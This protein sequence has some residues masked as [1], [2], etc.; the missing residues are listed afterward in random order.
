M[1]AD[2]PP[3]GAWKP[4]S[5]ATEEAGE[6]AG[7]AAP[8]DSPAMVGGAGVT[9]AGFAGGVPGSG[10][11]AAGAGSQPQS[12]PAGAGT[13]GSGSGSDRPSSAAGAAGAIAAGGSAGSGSG[14]AGSP[15]AMAGASAPAPATGM[16]QFTVLT[17]T[18][19]G[20][21]SPKNIG[22]IWIARS[23]GEFV[24]TLEVWASTR[25]RYLSRWRGESGSNKVDAV[26]SATLK[27][28]VSHTA[29]W[30]LTD[31][32]RAAVAPGEYK[33]IVEMTDHEGAGD[34]T[35]VPFTLGQPFSTMPA[36]QTHFVDMTLT[37]E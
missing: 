18:L 8:D 11:T 19:N 4:E 6:V 7:A 30:N 2:A 1:F 36:D 22:A 31:S 23:S 28:H 34:T 29:R 12:N 32:S 14:A 5:S 3:V 21:Y 15:A 33:V 20:E 10:A 9:G 25:V 27:S 37:V 17:K 16:L 26:T 24:K 13:G 35:E